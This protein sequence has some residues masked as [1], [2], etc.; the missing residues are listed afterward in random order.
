MKKHILFACLLL[1]LLPCG[2]AQHWQK[3]KEDFIFEKPPFDQG[4]ASTIVEVA[5]G[6]LLAACFGGNKEGN[7][8]VCI[9]MAA[10]NN[11]VWEKPKRIVEGIINDTLRYPCWNPV[12]FKERS[13]TLF[14]F[15]KVG[16]VTKAWWGEYI[17][18]TDDGKTWSDRQKLP[19]NIFGPIKNKPVQLADGTILSPSSALSGTRRI[20]IIEKSTDA[21]QSWT[22]I[23]VDTAGKTEAT[24][25]SLFLYP[26]NRMQVLC[27]GMKDTLVQA[28]SDD[29]GRTWKNLSN[30]SLLNPNSGT[31]G[32][33]LKNGE[34]LLVYNPTT[35][36]T[37]WYSGREKLCVAASKD[38]IHW[39]DVLVL[40]DGRETQDYSYPAVIQAEDGKVHITYSSNRR[41]IRHVVLEQK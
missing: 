11:G 17:T 3:I 38:G 40:E 21:G 4:H 41:N 26:G 29:N 32:L 7:K 39:K 19:A 16:P 20:V 13:G 22:R 5:S 33:T 31:D 2:M 18:S 8:D 10:C 36:G 34:Q 6:K 27:R 15:Y 30:T 24:Q 25:P 28:W 14:L 23:A 35:R 9:W 12:L 1:G 37:N